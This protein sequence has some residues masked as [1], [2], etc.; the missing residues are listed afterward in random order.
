MYCTGILLEGMRRK[1]RKGLIQ[2]TGF[3]A[4]I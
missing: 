3:R 2:I 1:N 4:G